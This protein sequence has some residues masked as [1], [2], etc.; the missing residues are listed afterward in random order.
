MVELGSARVAALGEHVGAGRRGLK[1]PLRIRKG[2]PAVWYSTHAISS[3]PVM[4]DYA[5]SVREPGLLSVVAP[6]HDE[7]DKVDA[8]HARTVAALD[9]LDFELVLVDDG[10]RDGTGERAA[11]ARGGGRAREGRRAVAQLRPPGRDQRRPRARARR[12]R[13]D[14]RRRPPGPARADPRDARRLARAAPTSS[15][16][17][18][19]RGRGRRASSSPPR[20][21]S[22][23]CSPSSRGSSSRNDS[24]DFRLMD[25]AP[26]D[27][28]LSMPE[29]NRFLRGMT[30][31]VGFTQT[32]VAYK[33][34]ARTG[35]RDEVHARRRCC[36]S[37][38]T[39]SRRSRTP[40][41][42]PRRCSASRSRSSPSWRSR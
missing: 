13:G 41:C 30:V 42:R 31:W 28:L 33:R 15:T 11:R 6:M 19:S 36:A 22:T 2:S 17:C 3:R 16:P 4:R 34:D 14:D 27:A 24:G 39:R 29:R 38:S 20:A 37:R 21:G 5:R 35:G 12:R 23:A 26:L 40:R 7:E 1:P 25:R 9:G 8:F 32:A 10:S 18:A